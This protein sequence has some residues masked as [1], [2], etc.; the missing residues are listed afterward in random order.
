MY[1]YRSKT[2]EIN[3]QIYIHVHTVNHRGRKPKT[4]GREA[5]IIEVKARATFCL[6]CKY[7]YLKISRK[8]LLQIVMMDFDNY[9]G[10]CLARLGYTEWNTR[11]IIPQK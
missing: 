11:D 2:S 7:V 5:K 10:C 3:H 1:I 9:Q 6:T 4:E 8:A